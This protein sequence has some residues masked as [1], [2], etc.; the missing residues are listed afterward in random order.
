[1]E[2]HRRRSVDHERDAQRHARRHRY[3]ASRNAMVPQ[4]PG[5]RIIRTL[6]PRSNLTRWSGRSNSSRRTRSAGRRATLSLEPRRIA[7]HQEPSAS[8]EHHIIEGV[9]T[10]RAS[11]N[12]FGYD[13]Q[14]R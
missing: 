6:Q 3:R 12:G 13:E 4:P 1:L 8:P 14:L 10:R 7:T 2:P 9:R 5:I 11:G